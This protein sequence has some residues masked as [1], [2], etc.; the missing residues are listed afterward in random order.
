MI[1]QFYVFQLGAFNDAVW[2][3]GLLVFYEIF[4]YLDGAMIRLRN[5]K[6]GLL[7][8]SELQ[9]TEAF[10]RDLDHYLGKEWRKNYAPRYMQYIQ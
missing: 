4:R 10:E 9:R 1:L 5:T 3:D 2:A 6:I 8:F 7:P